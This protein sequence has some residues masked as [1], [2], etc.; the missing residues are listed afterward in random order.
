MKLEY[1]FKKGKFY[2]WK[3]KFAIAK[4]KKVL[5]DAF[6]VIKDKDEI[7]SIIEQSKIKNNKNMI[8]IDKNWK[9]F[10][11]DIVFPLNVVGVTANISSALA[12]A[13]VSIFP[14]SSY[15]RDHFLVKERSTGKAIKVL[16][17]IGL[18][19]IK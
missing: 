16:E 13:N 10:T 1:Y 6:A 8:N 17:K 4:T 5:P 2:V 3:E 9:I 18:K 11:L 19:L 12:K 14:I 15:S 7:T